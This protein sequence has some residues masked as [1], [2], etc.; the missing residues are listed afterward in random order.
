MSDLLKNTMD[1]LAAAS[2][3]RRVIASKS[4]VG[5]EWLAKLAQGRIPDPGITRIQKLHDY[6]SRQQ[7]EAA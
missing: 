2:E 1:L 3:P 5:Y 4:G 7:E 6:L